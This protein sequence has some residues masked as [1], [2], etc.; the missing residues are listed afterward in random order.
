MSNSDLQSLIFE[1]ASWRRQEDG[2]RVIWN[3]VDVA[4]NPPVHSPPNIDLFNATGA[5]ENKTDTL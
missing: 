3:L 1:H 2:K 4:H 5:I